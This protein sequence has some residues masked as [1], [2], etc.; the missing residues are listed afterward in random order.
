MWGISNI[1]LGVRAMNMPTKIKKIFHIKPFF[2]EWYRAK[3]PI[4]ANK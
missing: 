2:D 1:S 4:G 3:N